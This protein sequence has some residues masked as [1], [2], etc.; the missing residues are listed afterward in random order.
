MHKIIFYRNKRELSQDQFFFQDLQ[1]P[2]TCTTEM[3]DDPNDALDYSTTSFWSNPD[4]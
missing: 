3:F 2:S 1:S 4:L